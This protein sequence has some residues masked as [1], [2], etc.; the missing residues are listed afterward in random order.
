MHFLKER[1]PTKNVYL[2]LPLQA[3]DSV[4]TVV[5]PARRIRKKSS[6][7]LSNAGVWMQGAPCYHKDISR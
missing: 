7:P 2:I 3:A 4:K 5:P 6:G 1:I